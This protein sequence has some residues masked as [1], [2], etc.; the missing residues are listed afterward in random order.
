M[1]N[2]IAI[3]R[4]NLSINTSGFFNL[5]CVGFSRDLGLRIFDDWDRT[6]FLF[7]LFLKI[8]FYSGQIFFQAKNK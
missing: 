5:Y 4:Y 2:I 1:E 6:T 8:K 7:L 3:N